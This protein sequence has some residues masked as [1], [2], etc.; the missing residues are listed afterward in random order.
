MLHLPADSAF[1]PSTARLPFPPPFLPAMEMPLLVLQTPA[2]GTRW[3]NA[4]SKVT[5]IWCHRQSIDIWAIVSYQFSEWLT[6]TTKQPTFLKTHNSIKYMKPTFIMT[7]IFKCLPVDRRWTVAME[8]PYKPFIFFQHTEKSDFFPLL[9]RW[10]YEKRCQKGHGN[11]RFPT[12]VG[13]S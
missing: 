12:A 13:Q 8:N 1:S 5:L 6:V 4:S 2:G 3:K 11:K 9:S 10:D 7:A